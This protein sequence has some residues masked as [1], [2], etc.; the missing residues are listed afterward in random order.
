[1]DLT[2]SD[3]LIVILLL[4]GVGVLLLGLRGRMHFNIVLVGG[5]LTTI[6]VILLVMEVTQDEGIAPVTSPAPA[7]SAEGVASVSPS[8]GTRP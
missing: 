2:G 7:P 1:M 5:I 8:P 6:A 3:W 4:V